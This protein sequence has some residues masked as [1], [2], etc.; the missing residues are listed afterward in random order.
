MLV[1]N[2]GAKTGDT[3]R[4]DVDAVEWPEEIIERKDKKN[5]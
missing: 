1:T 3:R 4:D 2:W 5:K